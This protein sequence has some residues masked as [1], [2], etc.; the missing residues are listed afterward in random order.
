MVQYTVWGTEL[1]VE[2]H[3][4]KLWS[5]FGLCALKEGRSGRHCHARLLVC[6]APLSED[7]GRTLPS[8]SG[9]YYTVRVYRQLQRRPATGAE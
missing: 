5:M 8:H 7:R 4:F 6:R 2:G 3:S 1:Q 9:R